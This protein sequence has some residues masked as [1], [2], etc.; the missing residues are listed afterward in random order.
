M[1]G[2]KPNRHRMALDAARTLVVRGRQARSKGPWAWRFDRAAFDELLATPGAAGI[3]I[4]AGRTEQGE[5]TLVMIA[6]DAE[7]RELAGSAVMEQA[8]PCPPACDAESR[9]V[10]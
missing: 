3:R 6:T 9:L 1:T 4:Y 8:D 10:G 5:E 7:G 2:P